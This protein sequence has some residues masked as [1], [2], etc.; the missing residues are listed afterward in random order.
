M[1]SIWIDHLNLHDLLFIFERLWD[2]L[3]AADEEGR[4]KPLRTVPAHGSQPVAPLV[5]SP[6]VGQHTQLPAHPDEVARVLVD[7]RPPP[8]ELS[9]AQV[10]HVAT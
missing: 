9:T 3:Q 8:G 7:Q 2:L 6:N 10:I 5:Q 4:V 1:F